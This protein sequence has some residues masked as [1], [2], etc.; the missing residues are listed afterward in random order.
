MQTFISESS[1][2]HFLLVEKFFHPHDWLLYC[3]FA[4]VLKYELMRKNIPNHLIY[5]YSNIYSNPHT[6]HSVS[7]I[8]L[9]RICHHLAFYLF[10][11][12]SLSIFHTS[13]WECKFFVYH[14]ISSPK[15]SACC[16]F[17]EGFN[18]YVCNALLNCSPTFWRGTKFD[19]NEDVISG[20]E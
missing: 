17:I 5:I 15:N 14:W 7:C 1:H 13:L 3:T 6:P 16:A 12:F 20:R 8:F 9:H 10:L 19:Q 18:K 2:S 4:S 11:I